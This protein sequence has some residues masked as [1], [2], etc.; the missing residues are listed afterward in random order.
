MKIPIK[1]TSSEIG[2]AIRMT[3]LID[4]IFLL[5]IFYSGYCRKTE[6]LRNS[7]AAD[8]ACTRGKAVQDILAGTGS[9]Y[10]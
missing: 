9:L 4:V 10:L 7:Q 1:A 3:P 5:L 6:G 2:L 8:K